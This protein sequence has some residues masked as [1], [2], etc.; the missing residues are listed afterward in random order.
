MPTSYFTPA[1]FRFLRALDRHNERAWFHAHKDDYER[2]VREPFLQLITDMQ[3]PLVTISEHYRADPRKNGGSLYRIYR[4]TRY[5]NNKLP[6]KP[7]QGSRFFHVRRHE[8]QAPGFYLHIEPGDCFAGGGMWH[9]EPDAL[10]HIRGFLVDNPAAWKRAT[11]GKAFGDLQLGGE[12]LIRPPRGYDPTH[13]L[14]DDLKRK[15]FIA[16]APFSEELACSSELLPWTV[17]TFKQVAPLVDYL[18]AAQ[19]LEF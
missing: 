3:Q 2:H 4:D 6:Y 5:S 11:R 19:E 1:T 8:I 10:K 13:E 18:C 14:I 16:S 12:S 17:A 9:P 7:W 15:D